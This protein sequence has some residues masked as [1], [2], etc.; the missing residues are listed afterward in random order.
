M[1]KNIG[2]DQT[3]VAQI[4]FPK[5]VEYKIE[6][7]KNSV[8]DGAISKARVQGLTVSLLEA[9]KPTVNQSMGDLLKVARCITSWEENKGLMA[10]KESILLSYADKSDVCSIYLCKD[11][12]VVSFIVVI[13]DSTADTVFEYNELGFDLSEKYKEIED[14]M[15]I[16][17]EEAEGCC[18]LLSRYNM[19]HKRG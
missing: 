8:S 3:T 5:M 4:L 7:V 11:N 19:I 18:G 10:L 15:I 17:N 12:Q 9:T 1:N 16:D 14:F 6:D 13:E 2:I